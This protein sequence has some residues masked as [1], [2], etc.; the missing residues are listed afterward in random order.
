M[1]YL[2]SSRVRKQNIITDGKKENRL[3]N[4]TTAEAFQ[5]LCL[6][7]YASS[8]SNPLKT[9]RDLRQAMLTFFLMTE[10]N[11]SSTV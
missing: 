5:T 8:Y 6:R 10:H 11:S 4:D 7:P 9:A 3:K 2:S 1:V